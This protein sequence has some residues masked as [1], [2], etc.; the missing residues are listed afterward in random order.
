LLFIQSGTGSQLSIFNRA[1]ADGYAALFDGAITHLAFEDLALLWGWDFPGNTA[2]GILASE[3][4]IR[5]SAEVTAVF[6]HKY[7]DGDPAPSLDDPTL[8]DPLIRVVRVP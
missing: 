3:M 5:K 2:F 1:Q 6:Q 7:L 4:G 8:V